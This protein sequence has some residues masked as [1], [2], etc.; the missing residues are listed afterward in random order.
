MSAH[1]TWF[2]RSIG[3]A[4]QQIRVHLVLRMLPAGVGL[5]IDRLQPHHP[6]Q[7]LH[8]L[9]VHRPAVARKTTAIR[10]DP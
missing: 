5:L 7:P 3:Q 1:Q 4:S 2:G 9:A 8:P 10:R 6:H